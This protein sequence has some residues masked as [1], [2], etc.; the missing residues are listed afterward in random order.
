M[1]KKY[2]KVIIS[3][4][5]TNPVQINGFYFDEPYDVHPEIEA[6]IWALGKIVSQLSDAQIRLEKFKSE[7]KFELIDTQ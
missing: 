3:D 5:P 1:I 7:N 6:L 2:G 4:D